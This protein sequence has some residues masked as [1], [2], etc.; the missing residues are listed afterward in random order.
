[1][2]VSCYM[3]AFSWNCCSRGH[4]WYEWSTHQKPKA[5]QGLLHRCVN[6]CTCVITGLSMYDRYY[7]RQ[8]TVAA[9]G[10]IHVWYLN[11]YDIQKA[12]FPTYI[13]C[14]DVSG[15]WC[16]VAVVWLLL[17]KAPEPLKCSETLCL[18]WF[19]YLK[20]KQNVFLQVEVRGFW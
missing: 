2:P 15:M 14:C 11:N 19:L 7:K 5:Q 4:D 3:E 13:Y 17:K 12:T 20:I 9:V 8:P 18:G 1:M 6:A 16:I 10:I